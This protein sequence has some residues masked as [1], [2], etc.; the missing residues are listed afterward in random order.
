MPSLILFQLLIPKTIKSAPPK[1]N[2]F[3]FFFALIKYMPDIE[4]FKD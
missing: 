1:L 4:L 3:L 2:F